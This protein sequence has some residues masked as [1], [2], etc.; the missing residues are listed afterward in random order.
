VELHI[1]INSSS[2]AAVLLSA[3]KNAA[4]FGRLSDVSRPDLV[5]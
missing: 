2:G 1:A 5:Q 3:S 4:S